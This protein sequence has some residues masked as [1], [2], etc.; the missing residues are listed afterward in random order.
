MHK[1]SWLDEAGNL[2]WPTDFESRQNMARGLFGLELVSN[3]DYWTLLAE[4]ELDDTYQAPWASE[5]KDTLPIKPE[6]A[7]RRAILKTLSPEQREAVREL[8]RR[9]TKGQLHSFCVAIDDRQGGATISLEKPNDGHNEQLEIH[10]PR[11][12]ELKYDQFHWLEQFSIVFGK[13][14][15]G[16][17]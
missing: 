8:V 10:S 6:E 12:S 1:H 15:R 14:E 5:V 17:T 2:I 9:A 11:Q 3:V 16:L 13:D 4:D 7:K